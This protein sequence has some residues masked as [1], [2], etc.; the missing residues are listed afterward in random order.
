MSFH[1]VYWSIIGYWIY[2]GIYCVGRVLLA[3]CP[4]LRGQLRQKNESDTIYSHLNSITFLLYTLILL[5][6]IHFLFIDF[7][8]PIYFK[9]EFL[10][11]F[12][13]LF[14]NSYAIDL[15]PQNPFRYI[16]TFGWIH[17]LL[18]SDS[19]N[20]KDDG[21]FCLDS[22]FRSLNTRWF[23][24]TLNKNEINIFIKTCSFVI[25]TSYTF[26]N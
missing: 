10:F 4:S 5:D 25:L 23:R 1:C 19:V 13:P 8:H 26:Q 12:K 6:D 24:L 17:P 20:K 18:W 22:R 15:F 7:L 9:N 3:E 14:N 21:H 11:K 2:M 16:F